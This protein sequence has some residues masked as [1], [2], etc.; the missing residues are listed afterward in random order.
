MIS[1]RLSILYLSPIWKENHYII[2]NDLSLD[3]PTYSIQLFEIIFD[4]N[5]INL[6]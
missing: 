5:E 3:H 4:L 6:N 1:I 2:K